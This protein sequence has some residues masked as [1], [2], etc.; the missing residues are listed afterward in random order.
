VFSFA[1]VYRAGI[2]VTVGA[3]V[4][5]IPAYL[6]Y[7]ADSDAPNVVSLTFEDD[8]VCESIGTYAF[9]TNSGTVLDFSSCT[10][11]PTLAD[12]N[13]HGVLTI[14]VPTALYDEWRVATNWS[15]NASKIVAK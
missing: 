9:Y 13:L 6:F 14:Y 3:N 2:T 8:S 15:A 12:A 10:Q 11:I 5:R 1:G 7:A 4:K